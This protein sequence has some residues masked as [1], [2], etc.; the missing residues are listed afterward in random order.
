MKKSKIRLTAAAL[1]MAM[2]LQTGSVLPF[3]GTTI[4]NKVK[5]AEVTA[6][7]QAATTTDVATT[8]ASADAAT[9]A[10]T[11]IIK[12]TGFGY[13]LMNGE[14]MQLD[15]AG[16]SVVYIPVTVEQNGYMSLVRTDDNSEEIGVSVWDKDRKKEIVTEEMVEGGGSAGAFAIASGS[17]YIRLEATEE[18]DCEIKCNMTTGIVMEPGV[19]QSLVLE[20]H[21]AKTKYYMEVEAAKTGLLTLE[22][23]GN[24]KV[25]VSLCSESKEALSAK[26]SIEKYTKKNKKAN[27]NS[28]CYGVKA[29]EKYLICV[30][31]AAS[32]KKVTLQYTIKEYSS[33]GG[34]KYSSAT[35]LSK[36]KNINGTKYAGSAASYYQFKKSSYGRKSLTLKTYRNQGKLTLR[37][38]YKEIKGKNKGKILPVKVNG[39][40]IGWSQKGEMRNILKIPANWPNVTYYV[41]IANESKTASGSFQLNV[42]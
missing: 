14:K 37:L 9:Q 1:A 13:A 24:S 27:K 25:T 42:K 20:K 6:T 32:V 7:T 39:K 34:S 15:F 30:S 23:K 11:E 8:A 5:A 22:N 31:A 33:L 2:L 10:A 41:R 12:E 3:A 4:C 17:Y 21:T 35:A 18:L 28:T 16:A 40:Q 29:G 19:N 26:K 36:G 38:Y